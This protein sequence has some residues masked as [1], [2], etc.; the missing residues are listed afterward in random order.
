M[1]QA[2]IATTGLVR[3]AKSYREASYYGAVAV[4]AVCRPEDRIT[5]GGTTPSILA[6]KNGGAHRCHFDCHTPAAGRA[7]TE[8]WLADGQAA[9]G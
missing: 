5:T 2:W 7:G 8:G 4:A 1:G 9:G 3:E 6:A